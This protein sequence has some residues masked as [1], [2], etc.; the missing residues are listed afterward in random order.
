MPT[1]A[2]QP[3]AV[4]T[5]ETLVLALTLYQARDRRNPVDV[6]GWAASFA[7]RTVDGDAAV[8]IDEATP[9]PDGW[10]VDYTAQAVYVGSTDGRV[11]VVV[12]AA[13]TAGW[14]GLKGR[15]A[16]YVTSPAGRTWRLMAGPWAADRAETP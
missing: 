8:V 12:P 7:V 16:L 4:R 15:H 10:T 1:V 6:T 3:L 11:V 2:T 13:V 9:A 5:G 14:A